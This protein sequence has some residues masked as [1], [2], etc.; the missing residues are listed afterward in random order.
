[1]PYPPYPSVP[2]PVS[3]DDGD[4]VSAAVLRS[5]VADTVLLL[6]DPP[7]FAGTQTGG[8]PVTFTVTSGA[9][10]VTAASAYT[11]G[12]PVTPSGGG[13]PGGLTAGG[14]YYVT[15]VSGTTFGLA[16]AP[17]GSPVTYTS[18]GSGILEALQLTSNAAH[19]AIGLDTTVTDL[20]D[21]HLPGPAGAYIYGMLPGY[22]LAEV[23][24]P[25][26]YTGFGPSAG[27]GV[28]A[29]QGSS[30]VQVFGGQQIPFPAASGQVAQPQAA[31]LLQF[32]QAGVYRGAGNNWAAGTAWQDTGGPVPLDITPGRCPAVTLT[33]VSALTG[34]PGLPVP[35]N[36]AWPAP[37]DYPSATWVNKNVRD[38]IGFLTFAPVFEAAYSAGTQSLAAQ[39]SLPGTGTTVQL[40]TV[41]ADTRS[42]WNPATFTWTAPVPGVYYCYA[43]SATAA[44][45]TSTAA[46]AGLTVTSANYNSGTQF[47]IWG[48]P[49][50][51]AAV[52]GAVNSAV[53]ARRLRLNAGDTIKLA[54][55]QSDSASQAA[56]IQGGTWQPRLIT[57][58]QAA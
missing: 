56:V 33:W 34:N 26:T 45:L 27:A 11:A 52:P 48:A 20:W 19:T 57:V 1:V 54:A 14:I 51:A 32:T 23:T 21:S 17:G 12:T 38:T 41:T 40:D 53:T 25:F 8:D 7:L 39:S 28:M 44:A 3:Y 58:W 31:K 2:A 4:H 43:Q 9:V 49:Q 30:A 29:Q 35:D 36:D 18:S 6:S 24:A 47:T 42:A 16:T 13:L 55:F 10:A 15:G 22:Y 37:P 46:A 50:L 5:D